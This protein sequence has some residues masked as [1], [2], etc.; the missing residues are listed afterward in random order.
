MAVSLRRTLAV[1]HGLTMAVALLGITWWA[2]VGV[3]RTL[4]QQLEHSVRTTF[5][6]QSLSL[7]SNGRITPTPSPSDLADFVSHINRLVVVRDSAGRVLQVNNEL[8]R[9]LTPDSTSIRHA[10]AGRQRVRTATWSGGQARTVAGPVARGGPPGAAVLEVG[11]SLGPLHEAGR[12]VLERM[13]ITAL[14]GSLATLLGAYWLAGSALVPVGEI[15]AQARAIRGAAGQRITAHAGVEELAGL[16]RVLNDMLGRLER[17]HEWHRR[18]IRDLGHDLRTPITTMRAGIEVTLL[19]SRTTDEYRRVLAATMEEVDRLALIGDGLTLLGRLESG[20]LRPD[21]QTADVGH[22]VGHAVTRARERAGGHP[23]DFAPP[24]RPAVAPVDA[25]LLGMALD[26]LLDNAVRHTP[27]GTRVEVAIAPSPDGLVLT[28]ED[29][30]PGVSEE[31]LPHLF[32][33]FYRGDSARGR[34]GGPGLGLT[35]VAV[36]AEQHHG[37]VAA[38]PGRRGGLRVRLELPVSAED[39]GS[40]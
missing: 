40:A 35:V 17:T 26:Q 27:P 7:A 12:S 9:S 4:A 28:V 11:A 22:L 37:R 18:I 5:E 3:R 39:R 24:A 16:I 21:L 34:D 6:L 2:Y 20:A 32:D 8:A 33:R 14:L 31:L 1:R 23:V 19:G 29:E 36:I 15:A 13:L 25:R 38:E 10:L 30:G